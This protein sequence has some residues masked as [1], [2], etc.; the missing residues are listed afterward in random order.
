MARQIGIVVLVFLMFGPGLVSSW[1]SSVAYKG[2]LFVACVNPSQTDLQSRSTVSF[3]GADDWIPIR[4]TIADCDGPMQYPIGIELTERPRQIEI[5]IKAQQ[6]GQ[7]TIQRWSCTK[8]MAIALPETAC[9]QDEN[10][11]GSA[12]VEK[13][14]VTCWMPGS[15]H[16]PFSDDHIWLVFALSAD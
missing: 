13:D 14:T 7:D 15:L 4:M 16:S 3:Y 10:R 9:T 12:F 8:K 1:A 11:R 5:E 6:Q 2:I